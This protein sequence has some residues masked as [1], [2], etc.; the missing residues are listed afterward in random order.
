MVSEYI[1]G[2]DLRQRQTREP[3]NLRESLDVAVQLASA[4]NAAHEAGIIHRDIKPENIMLRE[5]GI[6]KVLD[7]G[8]AKLIVQQPLREV[9]KDAPTIYKTDPGIIIGTVAYMS[10]EQTRGKEID[11]RSDI[12]SMGVCLYEMLAGRLPFFEETVSDT[13]ASILKSDFP[14]PG[15]NVPGELSRILRKA[16]E[17]E[18]D[19]RYQTAKEFLLELKTFKH[20]L[21]FAEDLERSK[22]PPLKEAVPAAAKSNRSKRTFRIALAALLILVAGVAAALLYRRHLAYVEARQLYEEGRKLLKAR[23][24]DKIKSAKV[25]FEQAVSKDPNYAQAYAGLADTYALAE[26]YLGLSSR[27]TLPVA[28]ANAL[29]AIELEPSLGEAY[30]SLGNIKSKQWKWDD[31]RA[32]FERAT[33]LDPNYVPARQW[34]NIYLRNVGDYK[35]ALRQII[36]AGDSK[37]ADNITRVNI[38]ITHLVLGEFKAAEDVGHELVKNSGDFW[39]GRSWLGMVHLKQGRYV[40]AIR[41]LDVGHEIAKKS[42]TLLANLG[43]GYA[44]RRGKGDVEEAAKVLAQLENLYD[45]TPREATGQDLAKVYAGLEEKDKAFEWLEKDYKDRSG[46][47]PYVSWHPAFDSL[48]DDPRYEDL[49]RRMCLRP[50]PI[51]CQ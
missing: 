33:D 38:L 12:W 4:L 42:H 46:D 37:Q 19:C 34:Y 18:R 17:K 10:P 26:E 5:D 7:F 3:L 51:N 14:P 11:A 20:D 13:I 9:D 36:I 6:V 27:E 24:A 35:S 44:V 28:E 21:E 41:N 29:K 50:T 43:Y 23:Q 40:D 45:A 31:A 25:M 16:L 2:E 30:A 15:D 1:K 39:G 49:L 32:A 22:S 8:L 48:R 47:L